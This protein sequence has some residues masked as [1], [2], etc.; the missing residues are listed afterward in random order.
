MKNNQPKS[1]LFSLTIITLSGLILFWWLNLLFI[2]R[3]IY[4]SEDILGAAISKAHSTEYNLKIAP[5]PVLETNDIAPSLSR[6]WIL[7]DA[8]SGKVLADYQKDQV[9]PV[10][11]TTKIMTALV[12]LEKVPDLE[13]VVVIDRKSTLLT[14][15]KIQLRANERIKVIDLLYGMMINS[16]ND[17]ANSLADYVGGIINPQAKTWEERVKSFVKE[18]NSKAQTLGL[19]KTKFADPAGLEETTVSTA[20]EMAMLSKEAL[21][22]DL[23]KKITQTA[24]ITVTNLEGTIAHPLK[25]SNRLVGEWRYPGAIGVKTGFLPNNSKKLSAGHCLIAAAT[26]DN[27]TLIVA[28]FNTYAEDNEASARAG[29]ALLDYGFENTTWY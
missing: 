1:K 7:L 12:T 10:A 19:V 21:K 24:E 13:K 6:F 22:H 18:M 16:G 4:V 2:S 27:H 3:P 11:S 20:Y 26:R 25:N 14:G 23:F 17:A 15:S 8:D 29:K 5:Y 9:I 28:N